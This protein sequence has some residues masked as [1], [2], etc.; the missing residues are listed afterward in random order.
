MIRRTLA[1]FQPASDRA[2]DARDETPVH[3]EQLLAR[4][5]G[6][7]I[8]RLRISGLAFVSQSTVS[9]V[10]AERRAAHL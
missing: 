2:L 5:G 6:Q 1:T 9:I 8:V 7:L 4:P 10:V 3:F